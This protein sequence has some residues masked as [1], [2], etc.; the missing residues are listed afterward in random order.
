[1]I[2]CPAGFARQC[3]SETSSSSSG[4][5]VG[6]ILRTKLPWLMLPYPLDDP[7]DK[8]THHFF[9]I[10]CSSPSDHPH[11]PDHLFPFPKCLNYNRYHRLHLPE[12]SDTRCHGLVNCP[13]WLLALRRGCKSSPFLFNPITRTH[14][15]LPPLPLPTPWKH[16]PYHNDQYDDEITQQQVED[17]L[18]PLFYI[19]SISLAAL[20][21]DPDI[22]HSSSSSSC[23]EIMVVHGWDWR[24]AFCRPGHVE[25]TPVLNPQSR[26]PCR[27]IVALAYANAKFYA[28]NYDDNLIVCDT[29]AS[30]PTATVVTPLPKAPKRGKYHLVASG[31]ELFLIIRSWERRNFNEF[32]LFKFADDNDEGRKKQNKDK[33]KKRKEKEEEKKKKIQ[34]EE[35]EENRQR[36]EE[37]GEEEDRLWLRLMNINDEEDDVEEEEEEE[38]EEGRWLRMHTIGQ[39]AIFL[40]EQNS[41]ILPASESNECASNCIYYYD[42][43]G[44][45]NYPHESCVKLIQ[46]SL[47]E[48]KMDKDDT[49]FAATIYS[50]VGTFV[51]STEL[52]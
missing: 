46:F 26:Q 50:A 27:K 15:T 16:C 10:Y 9:C 12:I 30:P 43:F 41:L 32:R 39:R 49:L 37:E 18:G 51:L 4:G 47:E 38:E 33:E 24:L 1:M 22:S 52:T 45:I 31:Q 11:H 25:W 21:S 28:I 2:E 3:M 36:Q 20:P 40:C 34:E 8:N 13:G 7:C 23:C 42:F 6:D 19:P 17:R 35:E 14:I 29:A 5:D 44:E 48:K